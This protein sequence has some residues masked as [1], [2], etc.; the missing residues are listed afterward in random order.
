LEELVT[1][2]YD[3]TI[4]EKNVVEWCQAV[5]YK[6]EKLLMMME[7]LVNYVCERK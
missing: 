5:Q 6:E 2:F 7:A 4:G 3:D 1:T